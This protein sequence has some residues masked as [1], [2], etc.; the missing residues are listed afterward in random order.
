MSNANAPQLLVR[1]AQPG[2]IAELAAALDPEVSGEQLANRW[3]EQL[4]GHRE[5][6][7]AELEGHPIGTIS[8]GGARLQRPGSLRC[9]ALDVGQACRRRGIGT[10]LLAAVEEKAR[11]RNLVT[12]HLEV[13]VDNPDAIRLYERLGYVREPDLFIDRWTRLTADGVRQSVEDPSYVMVKR[14]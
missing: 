9:F 7:V 6:L 4:D 10:A 2:D 14:V 5:M 1:R 3:R 11:R 12:V 8:F 13:A